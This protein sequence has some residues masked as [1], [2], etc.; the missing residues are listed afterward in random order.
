MPSNCLNGRQEE[1]TITNC[2]KEKNDSHKD[3]L[4]LKFV[5]RFQQALLEKKPDENTNSVLQTAIK[6][7][8]SC[9]I[10]DSSNQRV[11]FFLA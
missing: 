4:K 7:L 5:V 2:G 10:G 3:E 6:N 9:I 1:S 8:S 11:F